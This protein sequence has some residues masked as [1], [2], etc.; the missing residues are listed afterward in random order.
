MLFVKAPFSEAFNVALRRVPGARWN[1]EMKMR[2]VPRM[3]RMKLWA[4]IKTAF[5][6]GTLVVGSRVAVVR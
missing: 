6:P 2:T 1:A 5:G 3:Q 4:A